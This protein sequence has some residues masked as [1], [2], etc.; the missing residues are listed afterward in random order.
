MNNQQRLRI[1]LVLVAVFALFA[2]TAS[3][4]SEMTS[5]I[6]LE[7]AGGSA[8]CPGAAAQYDFSVAGSNFSLGRVGD[9]EAIKLQDS[10]SVATA[11]FEVQGQPASGPA[12]LMR[13]TN[14]GS[15][16]IQFLL[17]RTTGTDWQFANFNNFQ[18]SVPGTVGTP[19]FVLDTNGNLVLRG[20]ITAPSSRSLK[21]E[22]Q[23]VDGQAILEKLAEMP[24]D[25]WVY[26]EQP[27]RRHIGP[28]TED[29]QAAFGV[30]QHG[31]GLEILDV[32]G[33]ALKAVQALQTEVLARDAKIAQL[34]AA[35]DELVKRLEA[36]EQSRK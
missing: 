21:S 31:L 20:T 12:N 11:V 5:K 8:E 36:L 7:C 24:I 33:V 4:Q 15:A 10:P 9:Q 25:S 1:A 18:I 29:F 26:N 22:F 17:D 19:Q 30:G 16:G 14:L 35:Q 2:A 6:R 27:D 34:T 32:S 23:H 28:T 3:A 13:L